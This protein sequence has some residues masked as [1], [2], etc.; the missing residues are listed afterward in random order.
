LL[1]GGF[2]RPITSMVVTDMT[3]ARRKEEMLRTLSHRLAE[4]QEAE[5]GRV[6]LVLHNHITQLLCAILVRSQAL[7]DK[8]S[9]RDMPSGRAA[10]KLRDM[11]GHAVEEVECI[12][13]NLRPSILDNL[14]LVAA[15][16]GTSTA[17]AQRTGMSVKLAC[18]RLTARLPADVELVLYR[19]FQN[20][21]ANVM[22]HARA[23]RVAVR[24]EQS[25]GF[26]QL[27]IKDNGVGF[28]ADDSANGKERSG[29]GLLSMRERA[30]S[31]GGLLHVTSDRRTGRKSRCAFLCR[32]APR[33]LTELIYEPNYCTS[34]RRSPD[35]PRGLPVIIGTRKRY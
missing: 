28:D 34:G 33:P 10:V 18:L 8:L 6:A 2:N 30:T 5:R 32:Q 17:F 23:R 19:I 13:H 16:R 20:A 15:L 4:A 27:S 11:L 21:L 22:Q 31:V 35:C 3:E 29:V 25:A 26:I 14:G 24:L 12:S 9:E 7:A 1:Q